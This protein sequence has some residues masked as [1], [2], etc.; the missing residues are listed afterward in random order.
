MSFGYSAGDFIAGGT[1]IYQ[2]INAL[3]GTQ[4]PSEEYQEALKE[5]SCFQHIFIQVS[6]MAENPNL[7]PATINAASHIVLSSMTLIGD[8]VSKTKGYRRQLSS[9]QN[10]GWVMFK[11]D[12]LRALKAALHVKLTSISMLLNTAQ[13]YVTG[14]L[15]QL[16][17]A[18]EPLSRYEQTPARVAALAIK[19]VEPPTTDTSPM[20]SP[21]VQVPEAVKRPI[22]AP[23]TNST[24]KR[25][26]GDEELSVLEARNDFPDLNSDKKADTRISMIAIAEHKTLPPTSPLPSSRQSFEEWGIRTKSGDAVSERLPSPPPN[27]IISQATVPLRLLG[28]QPGD[29]DKQ[30]VFSFATSP[31]HRVS[32]KQKHS[33]TRPENITPLKTL[34]MD[35]CRKLLTSYEAYTIRKICPSNILVKPTWAKSLITKESLS[36]DDILKE[37]KRLNDSRRSVK[38][39]KDALM[40][41][42]Q[43]QVNRVLDELREGNSDANFQWSVAQLDSKIFVNKRG[44]RETATITVYVKRAPIKGVNPMAPLASK[45]GLPG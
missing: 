32:S 29:E 36:E 11:S 18:D 9:W 37:I 33:S 8:F 26:I 25:F 42:Q 4:C 38:Y 34:D 24:P 41:F 10:M 12:E 23:Y 44:Q 17:H 35:T 2:L 43:G 40:P 31:E 28:R 7:C 13:L 14:A 19:K 15:G 39:K 22:E 45:E 20:E 1:L 3:S 21:G 27:P 5:L 30:P 6:H 16:D